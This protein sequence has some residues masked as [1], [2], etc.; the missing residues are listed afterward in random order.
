M[1]K[2]SS[3]QNLTYLVKVNLIDKLW[4]SLQNHWFELKYFPRSWLKTNRADSLQLF[5]I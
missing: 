2:L 3:T 1:C 4:F 5:I